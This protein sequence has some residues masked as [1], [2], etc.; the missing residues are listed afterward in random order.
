MKAIALA[1]DLIRRY[2]LSPQAESLET[3]LPRIRELASKGVA[4]FLGPEPR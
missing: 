2:P 3:L 4:E 1:E